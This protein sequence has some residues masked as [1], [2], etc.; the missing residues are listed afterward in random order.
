MV[1]SPWQHPAVPPRARRRTEKDKNDF[2]KTT[3][4]TKTTVTWEHNTHSPTL[5]LPVCSAGK[6]NDPVH[7]QWRSLL[8]ELLSSYSDSTNVCTWFNTNF[9]TCTWLTPRGIFQKWYLAKGK[10]FERL[11]TSA[12]HT[13]THTHAQTHTHTH[14]HFMYKEKQ[15]LKTN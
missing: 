15:T 1:K 5:W 9:K 10:L 4:E 3:T 11:I 2:T 14:T 6:T 12:T 8:K 13:H 7:I